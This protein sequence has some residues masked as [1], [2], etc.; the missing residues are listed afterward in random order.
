MGTEFYRLIGVGQVPRLGDLIKQSKVR[1]AGSD[2]GYSWVLLGD[3]L[4]KVR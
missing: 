1:I 4:L 2:V 3:P